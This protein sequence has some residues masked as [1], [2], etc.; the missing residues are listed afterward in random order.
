MILEINKRTID[1]LAPILKTHFE[2]IDALGQKKEEKLQKI[3]IFKEMANIVQQ[4]SEN[5][6]I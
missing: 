2:R 5:E 3:E 1:M 6:N 4:L